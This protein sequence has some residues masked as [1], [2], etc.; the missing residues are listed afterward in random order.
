MGRSVSSHRHRNSSAAQR[1]VTSAIL[2][3]VSQAI[4]DFQ[5]VVRRHGQ[6]ALLEQGDEDLLGE[7]IRFEL[8]EALPSRKGECA[9]PQ[10]RVRSVLGYSTRAVVR[11][12]HR[13]AECSLAKSRPNQNR[14]TI[15]WQFNAT[16]RLGDAQ[17]PIGLNSRQA[18]RPNSGSFSNVQVV[19][20][21]T[22][23]RFSPVT[24]LR[25]PFITRKERRVNDDNTAN[26]QN[27]L[28]R[29]RLDLRP[30]LLKSRM[31]LFK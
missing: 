4:A 28:L 5:S 16:F 8:H 20:S 26:L 11:F 22:K 27:S 3:V 21:V 10:A 9:L 23:I 14:R 19:Y 7:V 25:D 30:N 17:F 29:R 6:I 13:D 24:R 15:P 31:H 1:R 12:S 18:F 2:V